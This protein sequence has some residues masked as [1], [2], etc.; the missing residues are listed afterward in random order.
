MLVEG[1]ALTR[2]VKDAAGGHATEIV[3]PQPPQPYALCR[4]GR[5]GSLPL[6]DQEP[7]Y[8]CFEEPPQGG[9]PVPKP[10]RWEV[11][12]PSWPGLALKADGPVRVAGGV[13]IEA[14]DGLA[15]R[16]DRVSLCRCGASRS[17]PVC[18][19]S[20]KIVGYREGPGPPS[21]A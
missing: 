3:E 13:P 12:D 2:L 19:G 4:C 6:C 9:G 14:D 15:T 20:H 8:A 7:P 11:P 16:V 21:A 17:Q 18:D 5:S 1:L 10:F